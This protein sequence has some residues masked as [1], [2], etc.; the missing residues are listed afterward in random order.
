MEIPRLGGLIR[1]AATTNT[2][3]HSNTRILNSLSKARDQTCI[4]MNTIQVLELLSH[5][6]NTPGIIFNYI[7]AFLIRPVL[8][9]N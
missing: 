4:L 8:R 9:R 7:R 6:R 1:A 2:T 3:A 5:D